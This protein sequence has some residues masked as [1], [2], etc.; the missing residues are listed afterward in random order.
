[1]LKLAVTQHQQCRAV[2]PLPEESTKNTLLSDGRILYLKGNDSVS[3]PPSVS[4]S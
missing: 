4:L 2:I 3:E 1:M